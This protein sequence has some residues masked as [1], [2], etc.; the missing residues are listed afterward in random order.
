M[1][2]YGESI[3]RKYLI[4]NDAL[5]VYGIFKTFHFIFWDRRINFSSLYSFLHKGARFPKLLSWKVTELKGDYKNE[6][7]QR[8]AIN[9]SQKARLKMSSASCFHFLLS[10]S[11]LSWRS[12]HHV[13][14]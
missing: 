6:E 3:D 9:Y 10:N 2:Y 5:A 8:L 12:R 4:F 1:E 14:A 13:G 7:L 11:T